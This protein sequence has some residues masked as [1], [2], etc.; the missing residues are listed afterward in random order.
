MWYK[1]Y[2]LITLR[3]HFFYFHPYDNSM[4]NYEQ[5]SSH[6]EGY[7]NIMTNYEQ[8]SSHNEGYGNSMTNYDTA[9]LKTDSIKD[10]FSFTL[11]Q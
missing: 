2:P 5:E 6:N 4:T 1:I 7:D 10:N 3:L 8:E 11:T 9:K